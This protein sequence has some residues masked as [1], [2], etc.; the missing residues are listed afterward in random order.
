M[1]CEPVYVFE[2]MSAH[3]HTNAH[4]TQ[5]V[6]YKCAE[7]SQ[8]CA[9]VRSEVPRG[10]DMDRGPPIEDPCPIALQWRRRKGEDEED[11]APSGFPKKG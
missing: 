2:Q 9:A 8:K 5:S 3:T 4:H 11:G 7:I 6:R 10:P 1:S